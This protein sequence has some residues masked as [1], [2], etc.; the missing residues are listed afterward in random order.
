VIR[1]KDMSRGLIH[2]SRVPVVYHARNCSGDRHMTSKFRIFFFGFI[3]AA[4]AAVTCLALR[5]HIIEDYHIDKINGDAKVI[6]FRLKKLTSD[7]P[8]GIPETKL[9]AFKSSVEEKNPLP[10]MVFL[11]K[12]DRNILHSVIRQQLFP[13][14]RAVEKIKEDF[15]KRNIEQK[16]PEIPIIRY[17]G[18][19]SRVKTS[20]KF[21]AINRPVQG[22]TLFMLYPYIADLR[23]ITRL[24]LEVLLA[25][26]GAVVIIALFYIISGRKS[27]SFAPNEPSKQVPDEALH[28]VTPSAADE[29]DLKENLAF[30]GA[31]D[32]LSSYIF[33][34]FQDLSSRHQPLSVSLYLKTGEKI[35]SKT[36]ELKGT[37]F[38][39]IDSNSYDTL[40]LTSDIGSGLEGNAVM[41]LNG[42]TRL[43][44]PLRHDTAILGVMVIEGI[45]PFE[46]PVVR[47]ITE[48]MNKI[49]GELSNYLVINN[50]MTDTATSL[51]SRTYLEIQLNQAQMPADIS[52]VALEFLP[53]GIALSDRQKRTVFATI[54]PVIR[55]YMGPSDFIS[56]TEDIL[57][58]CMY[59]RSG[60]PAASAASA[61]TE[62]LQNYRLKLSSGQVLSL[63]PTAGVASTD[64][65][66]APSRLLSG[67][68]N[69]LKKAETESPREV[70]ASAAPLKDD[71]E[72][73]PAPPDAPAG[74]ADKEK[75]AKKKKMAPPPPM[76][77]G[78]KKIDGGLN[79]SIGAKL[80]SII[81]LLIV[82]SLVGMIF[83]TSYFFKSDSE[84]R[85]KENNLKIS[86]ITALKVKTDFT[87]LIEKGGFI[88]QTLISEG[89]ATSEDEYLSQRFFSTD[90]DILYVA[91]AGQKNNIPSIENGIINR[92]FADEHQITTKDIE[93]T[94]TTEAETINRS[95]NLEELAHNVSHLFKIPMIA[96]S[97]PYVR[98]SDSKASSILIIFVSV[99]RFNQAVSKPGITKTFI[100]N[101]SG[102]LIAHYN[103]ALVSSRVNFKQ[104]PIV[105]M[106][107]T[108]PIDN[109]LKRYSDEKGVWYIAS[110]KKIGFA[111]GGV[112]STVNEKKAFEAVSRIQFR[113]MIITIIV[114]NLAILIVYFF[115]KTLTGPVRRLVYAAEQIEQG[116]FEID[117]VKTSNDEIGQ[118]TESFINMGKGLGEREK[119]KDAFGKFVN[120]E[121]AEKVLRD[122][123]K[124]GGERKDVAIF[125]SDIRNFTAISEKL[126]PEEVVEFL[127]DY[128]TRMV[129]CVNSTRGVV[130]KFIG[131]AIMAIWG[132]PVSH[133]ND[134]ENA[135]NSALMMRGAL[136]DFNKGRGG[137]KR[138][139]I[140]IGCGINTG[141]TLVGQIGSQD[142]MEYTVIGDAVNLAS[143]IEALNKPFGTDI[144]ISY[145][146]LMLVPDLYYVEKMKEI[147][148]KGKIEPQ[149]IYAVLG[150]K[151]DPNALKTIAQLRD[152]LGI[153]HKDLSSFDPDE[154]EVKYE[155]VGDKK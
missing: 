53:A 61:I 86:D 113:N 63:A 75:T 9:A 65:I 98:K 88:A 31:R 1:G 99:N 38:L 43:L 55:D 102:D 62:T 93:T 135:V 12:S 129:N 133:G 25:I 7:H 67:A 96:V 19:N 90:K 10:A 70:P 119:I 76:R 11:A 123:I 80:I 143:R 68:L 18:E 107:M 24:I 154:A 58:I 20:G 91:V 127:N 29:M 108:N 95:F 109:G 131:D 139:V 116:I 118:L 128:M 35:L 148:V 3:F 56:R 41:M 141:P 54:A 134:T 66:T 106:M 15:K 5:A 100:V 42:G 114:L 8:A 117:I 32:S 101:G 30:R 142:K 82:V 52:L 147:I 83:L 120:K 6:T 155:I 46:G 103:S 110:Y 4:A 2:H 140:Q 26:L 22:Y 112:I 78:K 121:I 39:K 73:T 125:F 146:S 49:T 57:V 144:L 37:T 115:S 153:E 149:Q 81:S 59:Q 151:D 72:G 27:P 69:A 60:E 71:S 138:P 97:A 13:S 28:Q 94:I 132:A 85:V 44:V 111:N 36:H 130:D 124:L 136:M 34:I 33:K 21:Y 64:T 74:V 87:A 50:I 105:Q 45:S 84:L 16:N 40:D 150:R 145:D 104:L 17:Y 122:E 126:E 14:N 47:Q 51:F 79:L 137:P 77:Q 48:E 23:I 89:T 92:Q 152:L